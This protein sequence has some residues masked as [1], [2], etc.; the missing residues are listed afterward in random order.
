MRRSVVIA[1]CTFALSACGGSGPD[2]DPAAGADANG[3][4]EITVAEAIDKSSD[5]VK[6]EPGKY[7]NTVEMVNLEIPGAPKEVQDMMK[8]VLSAGPQ[9]NEYCL[10]AEEAEKGFE[11]MAKQA[12]NEDECSVE[13]FDAAGGKIDAVMNCKAG[14]EGTARMTLSGVGTKTS[15]A[16]TMT[17]D[18]KAPDGKTMKMTMKSNQERIG[19]CAG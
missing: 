12:Q 9:T 18:A 11:E 17:I 8:Q 14:R 16:M 7:R 15:S 3:D 5:M 4:G 19:D 1:V 2:A 13:R 10:T 6:P